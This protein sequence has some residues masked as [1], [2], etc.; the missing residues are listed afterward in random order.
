MYIGQ[1]QD[2]A[3]R[4]IKQLGVIDPDEEVVPS[5]PLARV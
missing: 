5:A 2:G 3:V 1:V 4:T